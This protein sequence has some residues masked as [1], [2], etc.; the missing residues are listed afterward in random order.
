MP[1]PLFSINNLT[2]NWIDI[3]IAVAQP[4]EEAHKQMHAMNSIAMMAYGAVNQV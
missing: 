1:G 2:V 3:Q 4:V